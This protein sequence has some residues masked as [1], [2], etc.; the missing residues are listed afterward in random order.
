VARVALTIAQRYD[1][2]LGGGLAWVLRGLVDRLDDKR[3]AY[4]RQQLAQWPRK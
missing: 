1:F 2:V 4:Y 3:F